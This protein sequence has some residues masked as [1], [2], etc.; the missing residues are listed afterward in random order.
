MFPTRLP[1]ALALAFALGTAAH[2]AETVK[3][4]ILVDG[5]KKAGEQ[6]VT[7]QDDGRT[8]VDYIFKDNGRGPELKEEY[9]LGP[10]GTY[11]DYK[12]TGTTT[13]GAPI[14]EK[15]TRADG[16]S[17]WKSTSEE[18]STDAGDDALY[19][20]LGGTPDGTS[21]ALAIMAQ[22]GVDTIPLLPSGNLTRRTLKEVE[23]TS[24]SG[25]KQ[26]VELV[27][28]TGLGLTPN[29]AWATKGDKAKKIPPRL[30]ANV[31]PGYLTAI[32]EGWEANRDTL[33]KVQQEAEGQMVRDMA[34]RLFSPVQ[35]L[36]LIRNVR[37]FDSVKGTLGGP[38]D[39]YV[40]RGRI[41]A[42]LPTGSPHGGVER[43]IDGKGRVMLPGLFD[44]HAHEFGRWGGG[45]H[46]AAGVTTV[47][48]MANDNKTLQGLIDEALRGE[49][50]EPQIVTAGFL[51]GESKFSA[52]NGFVVKNLEEA[53]KAVDWY[54][55]H[56]YPQ[57]KIYSSFPKEALKDTVA[58][59]HA[60]GMRVSGHIPAF[61]RAQD[62]IDAGFDEI[63]HIN[64][65][66]LNFLV[67][68]E[69][70]TR[71]LER[72]RLPAEGVATMD[73]D[74]KPVQDFIASLKANDVAV[75]PTLATFDYI[76]QRPGEMSKAYEAIA[77]HLPLSLQRNLR[78]AEMNIPDDATAERY[79]KS[80][81]KMV[82]FVGR[83]HKAGVT[84]IPGTDA[85]PGFTLHRELEL[86]VQ[87]GMTPAEALQSATSVSAK[88][89]RVDADRG[90]IEPGLLADLVLVEGDP[91][92]DISAIRKV[93]LVVTQGRVVEPAKIYG[94]LGIRQF[95]Q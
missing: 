49:V 13:F 9:S 87:A 19:I 36:T 72:F 7:K 63:Q 75:D 78:T 44:M 60:R 20:P 25:E 15:F 67:T 10:D 33:L 34:K 83:M 95:V 14:D 64:Q 55:T 35:G 58:Y 57:L 24:A 2:A 89:A 23:V 77:D 11:A 54:S 66:M 52:R 40:L 29:F 85:I 76:R 31:V 47:R 8:R 93:A 86:Y 56:G 22:R 21:V 32:D 84:I 37:P 50:I 92:Q 70:D 45:L 18:G 4:V 39:V 73:F 71:T 69:T 27:A 16:K 81:E 43:E 65:I 17:F 62:A 5:G 42:V 6:V 26:T 94:E 41:A 28:F 61:L 38:S 46:I 80:Y 68:P 90:R 88:I 91:T 79:N 30:F 48:D 1:L 3:H 74:S 82:E 53:K 59:A 51:E 12:V